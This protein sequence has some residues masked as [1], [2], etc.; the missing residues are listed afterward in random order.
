[1]KQLDMSVHLQMIP[2]A[3]T[4]AAGGLPGT[5]QLRCIKLLGLDAHPMSGFTRL[6]CPSCFQGRHTLPVCSWYGHHISKHISSKRDVCQH[7]ASRVVCPVLADTY[8]LQ[9]KK[10][11]R[12]ASVLNVQEA[13]GSTANGEDP[14]DT[15]LGP[16]G[17][18][19]L[20]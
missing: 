10:M 12:N 7:R 9:T 17:C 13:S 1:M 2:R 5:R 8:P 4:V 11:V 14:L 6:F 15:R 3:L 19:T 20:H 18:F 16:W